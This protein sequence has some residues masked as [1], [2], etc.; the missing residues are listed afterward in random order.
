MYVMNVHM[1]GVGD[2]H[3]CV[4]CLFD[5]FLLFFSDKV[6]HQTQSLLIQ[7]G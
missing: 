5:Y 6:F 3:V 7:L 2:V 1:C 4:E